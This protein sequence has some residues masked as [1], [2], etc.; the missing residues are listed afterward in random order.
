[1]KTLQVSRI[2]KKLNFYDEHDYQI[3]DNKLISGN[4]V[5]KQYHPIT[6]MIFTK[7]GNV[8]IELEGFGTNYLLL[9]YD[10]CKEYILY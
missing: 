1:M 9:T 3:I 10:E 4:N 5:I 8:K 7:N 2:N 6:R